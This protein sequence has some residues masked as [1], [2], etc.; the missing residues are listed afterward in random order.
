MSEVDINFDFAPCA[1]L[2][3]NPENPIIAKYNRSF[4]A[5]PDIATNNARA[6]IEG[7]HSK[8]KMS[9]KFSLVKL[10]VSSNN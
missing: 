3:I 8:K 5:D 6:F 2:R 9:R 4:S 10:R 7:L 1:D